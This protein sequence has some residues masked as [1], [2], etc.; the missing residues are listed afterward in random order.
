MIIK[1]TMLNTQKKQEAITPRNTMEQNRK[2]APD[3]F[4]LLLITS[5][6]AV[7]FVLNRYQPLASD[8]FGYSM[9]YGTSNRPESLV[10]IIVSQYHH[11]HAVNGRFVVHCIAQ[12]F[13]MYDKLFFD[14]ANTMALL[15]T[16]LGITYLFADR[17]LSGKSVATLLVLALFVLMI[18]CSG[19]ALIWLVGSCNYLW[20]MLLIILFL[21]LLNAADKKLQLLALVL[22]P[23]AGNAHEG[24]SIG[25]CTYLGCWALLN[26]IR[27]KKISPILCAA[28][29]LV[30]I[31][32]TFN[33]FSPGSRIRIEA[34]SGNISKPYSE[35]GL[36]VSVIYNVI[37]TIGIQIISDRLTLILV[38]L[39]A[40]SA[41]LY[42]QRKQGLDD[43]NLMITSLLSAAFVQSFAILYSGAATNSRAW[44]GVF[45]FAFL[46]ILVYLVPFI[47]RSN[48]WQQVSTS[49]LI[50][51]LSA[52]VL[53][54]ATLPARANQKETAFITERAQQ[55][56]RLIA[57]PAKPP[58]PT[59]LRY[60]TD[61]SFSSNCFFYVNYRAAA[62]WGI[63]PFSVISEESYRKLKLI[64]ETSIRLAAEG[65][66]LLLP[67]GELLLMLPPETQGITLSLNEKKGRRTEPDFVWPLEA[68]YAL[69]LP[70][71]NDACG[72]H[73]RAT[74]PN[75]SWKDIRISADQ[76][77]QLQRDRILSTEQVDVSIEKKR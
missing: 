40:G 44:I 62:L 68:G 55:G 12:F 60:Q 32:L 29:I 13:L 66:L 37:Y 9:M 57:V 18:P 19:D 52:T 31:G 17:K 46:S 28:I 42:A 61:H 20:A 15:C 64:P 49:L 43:K 26:F 25:L 48:R 5:I 70:Q 16:T 53:F 35:Y 73:V 65:N 77:K 4:A 45:F 69:L 51:P 10:D 54:Q 1:T 23:L 63:R 8:D 3:W 6:A 36:V 72:L 56:C 67:N 14:I 58:Y 22:A 27:S 33:I 41:A 2:N 39:G 11:W 59:A 34:F 47:Q 50:V 30:A 75:G 74:L 7:F 38:L 24:I 76:L 71:P 21:L